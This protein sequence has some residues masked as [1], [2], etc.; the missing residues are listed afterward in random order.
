KRVGWAMA[1]SVAA[2]VLA[3]ALIAWDPLDRRL[4][5]AARAW[6]NLQAEAK[7]PRDLDAVRTAVLKLRAEFATTPEA[8]QAVLLFTHLPSPFD[9]L[10]PEEITADLRTPGQP[11]EVVA[12]LGKRGQRQIRCLAFSPDCKYL[13]Y[14]G[15]DQLVHLFDPRTHTE[16]EL[17]G[18]A[19]IVTGIAFS[20]DATTVAWCSNDG[21]IKF[22]DVATGNDLDRPLT[23]KADGNMH[24][25]A[26]APDGATLAWTNLGQVQLWDVTAAPPTVRR[27]LSSGGY[28][29]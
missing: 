13:A 5:P 20:P 21:V 27:T 22:W 12:V 1:A 6:K 28:A 2:L 25:L 23:T 9:Q 8:R 24:F 29:L 7:N 10:K 18:H 16:R 26:F 15:D 3:L 14:A 19:A 17:K 11:R 4:T